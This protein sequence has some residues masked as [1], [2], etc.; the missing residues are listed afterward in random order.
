[1]HAMNHS[2]VE[3]SVSDADAED[4]PTEDTIDQG[5]DVHRLN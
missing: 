2:N 5:K 1:M 3:I 4:E